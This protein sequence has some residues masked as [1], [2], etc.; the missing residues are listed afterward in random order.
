MKN[1]SMAELFF[2]VLPRS[3][4]FCHIQLHI[5]CIVYNV[6]YTPMHCMHESVIAEHAR[7][8]RLP[9]VCYKILTKSQTNNKNKTKNHRNVTITNET[10]FSNSVVY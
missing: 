9:S 3:L 4:L 1:I 6:P 8:S 2:Q 7:S 5:L 10:L